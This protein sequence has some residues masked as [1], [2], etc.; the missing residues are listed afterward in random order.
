MNRF[1]RNKF[2]DFHI[3]RRSFQLLKGFAVAVLS[4]VVSTQVAAEKPVFKHAIDEEP[5]ELTLKPGEKETPALKQFKETGV[6]AYRKDQ[7][8]IQSGKALYDQWCAACHGPD[9]KGRMGPSLVGENYTY[10]Q[11]ANDV[12]MFSI[13]YGGAFGAMQ[14]FS[15]RDLSQD[16]MLRIISYVRSL[17]EKK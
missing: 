12:G 7:A 14:A 15:K 13:I 6:N 2:V 17:D 10:P 9:A 1:W 8:A 4:A 5:I 11:T 3:E 16:E